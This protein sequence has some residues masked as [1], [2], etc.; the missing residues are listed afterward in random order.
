MT[1]LETLH[2]Q[3]TKEQ[4]RIELVK[5]AYRFN[6][7]DAN[8]SNKEIGAAKEKIETLQKEFDKEYNLQNA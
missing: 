6:N 2:K 4:K 3:I 7:L 5:N 1:I 8:F